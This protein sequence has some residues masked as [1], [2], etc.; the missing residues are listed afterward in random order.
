MKFYKIACICGGGM[1]SSFL[2]EMNVK[3]VIKDIGLK[4]VE[5]EHTDLSS[6]WPG[7]ADII[8]C[9]ADLYDNLKRY[10]DTIPIHNLLDKNEIKG[11][12]LEHFKSHGVEIK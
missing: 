11:K 1:G 2:L 8:V 9:G 6:A 10:G 3:D 12:L 7:I 5:V 4:D